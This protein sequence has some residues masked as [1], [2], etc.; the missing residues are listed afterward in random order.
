MSKTLQERCL[1][2]TKNKKAYIAW[3]D[4]EI[5]FSSYSESD[6]CANLALMASHNSDDEN[7]EVSSGFFVYDNDA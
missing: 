4:N 6:E 5:S 2:N 3:N 7:G 1:Q